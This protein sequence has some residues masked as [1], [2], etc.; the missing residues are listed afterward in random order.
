MRVGS[1][2]FFERRSVSSVS[3]SLRRFPNTENALIRALKENVGIAMIPRRLTARVKIDFE[4]AVETR[5]IMQLRCD[6][7]RRVVPG[8]QH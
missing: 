2:L 7:V 4:I 8:V 5:P 6:C 1:Q 3:S